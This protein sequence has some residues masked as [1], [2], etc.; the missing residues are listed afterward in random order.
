MQRDD[1][2]LDSARDVPDDPA[3]ALG[4]GKDR[5]EHADRVAYRLRRGGLA[6]ASVARETG[7][8][9]LALLNTPHELLNVLD[10]QLPH[11][12]ATEVRDEPRAHHALDSDDRGLLAAEPLDVRDV[13]PPELADR[14]RVARQ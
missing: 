10:A 8:R 6:V 14:E 5:G 1:R 7:T 2:Q 3:L 4:V 11:V 9:A 13:P 12:L